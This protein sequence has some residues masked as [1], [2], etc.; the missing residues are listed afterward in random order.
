MKEKLMKAG[1][2]EQNIC[3]KNGYLYITKKQEEQTVIMPVDEDTSIKFNNGDYFTEKPLDY[4]SVDV[5]IY[6]NDLGDN[7]N[8]KYFFYTGE[9]KKVFKK[10]SLLIY[11]GN[12]KFIGVLLAQPFWEIVTFFSL[13][14]EEV[15]TLMNIEK[16]PDFRLTEIF[17]KHK[18]KIIIK[19]Q[20][21]RKNPNTYP[22]KIIS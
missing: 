13:V 6:T 18:Y 15:P 5:H 21:F 17:N 2:A 4:E 20:N 12:N 16:L 22:I 1:I 10:N 3:F 7:F 8:G 19:V 14:E 11:E 9:Y